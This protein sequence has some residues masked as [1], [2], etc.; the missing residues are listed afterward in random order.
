MYLSGFDKEQSPIKA[1]FVSGGYEYWFTGG[2]GD[3]LVLGL[4]N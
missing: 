3:G 2:G 4:L 1:Y